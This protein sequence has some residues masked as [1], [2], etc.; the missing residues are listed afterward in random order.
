M[1]SVRTRPR[2]LAVSVY[3]H[4]K[5]ILSGK[6]VDVGAQ[7]SNVL[8]LFSGV[9]KTLLAQSWPRCWAFPSPSQT[10]P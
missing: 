4:Y 2:A 7:K 9:G 10:P 3:N 1:S 5:R 6:A 8:L